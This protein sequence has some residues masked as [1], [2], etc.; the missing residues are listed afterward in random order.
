L[1]IVEEYEQVD[2]SAKS[3]VTSGKD[4]NGDD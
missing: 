3:V 4:A 1:T 2:I